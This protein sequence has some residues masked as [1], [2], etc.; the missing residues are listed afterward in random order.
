LSE[1]A[2]GSSNGRTASGHSHAP[3]RADA[4][5]VINLQERE[6]LRIGF[7]LHDGPAQSMSA[8]LLQI[9]MLQDLRGED[10]HTGLA[11][12]RVTLSTALE[13][14][15]ELIEGLGCRDSGERDFVARVRA[16]VDHFARRYGIPVDLKVEGD[17]A[18]ASKSLQIAVF[19]I[20]QEALSNAGRHSGA[21]HVDVRVWFWP[22]EVR[23]E[24]CDD[25]RGFTGQP[26]G[27]TRR[28]RESFGMR[29][30]VERARLLDGDCAV[31]S[32]PDHGT[33]V[34]VRIP[35]WQ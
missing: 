14:V 10:L 27:M 23:F 8:A 28:G 24:V 20:V 16:C 22:S 15:Y 7:D 18:G 6:R 25:G 12:L 2:T 4:D 33:R 26:T 35:V 9:K 13:E 11:E 19:R 31:E 21:S 5:A 34:R 29:G 30:M 3:S 32:D 1:P 17:P